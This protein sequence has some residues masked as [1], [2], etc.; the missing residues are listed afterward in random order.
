MRQGRP[1]EVAALVG[2]LASKRCG[3]VTGQVIHI[4]RGLSIAVHFGAL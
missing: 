2:F 4:D 3:F 1:E